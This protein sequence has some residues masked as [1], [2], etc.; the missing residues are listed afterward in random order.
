MTTK[1]NV[2]DVLNRARKRLL[3]DFIYKRLVLVASVV[4]LLLFG[5]L[6]MAGCNNNSGQMCTP[7]P[8]FHVEGRVYGLYGR[9]GGASELMDDSYEYIGTIPSHTNLFRNVTAN[10]QSNNSHLVG[11]RLYQSG[12]NIILVIDGVY[13]LHRFVGKTLSCWIVND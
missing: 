5:V 9:W 4:S 11:A 7:A 13:S 8:L 6:C 12:E 2:G 10:F 1:N 3:R